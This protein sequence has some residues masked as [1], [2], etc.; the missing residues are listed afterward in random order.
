[1]YRN[2]SSPTPDDASANVEDE[3][4]LS[5]GTTYYNNVRTSDKDARV[6]E[7]DGQLP[8]FSQCNTNAVTAISE[9][10]NTTGIETLASPVSNSAASTVAILPAGTDC[11][12]TV[13][14]QG[15]VLIGVSEYSTSFLTQE[16]KQLIENAI[17]YLLGIDRPQSVDEVLNHKSSN[18]KF[19]YDGKLFI[20]ASGVVYDA[21]GRRMAR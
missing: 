1:M 4:Q 3:S 21:T 18:R 20:E 7:A 19:L 15:L 11:N 2:T 8:L 13:L 12:G 10:T 6:A 5:G 16:G 17:L 9:W 14:T